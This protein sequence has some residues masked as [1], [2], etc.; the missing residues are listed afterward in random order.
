MM[1]ETTS[2]LIACRT[3]R[4]RA[5]VLSLLSLA[6]FG[7]AVGVDYI[8]YLSIGPTTL[9]TWYNKYWIG[10]FFVCGF[11]AAA[12]FVFR[13]TVKAK[14]EYLFLAITLSV[15]CFSSLAF[16]VNKTSW[17]VDV[18]YSYVVEWSEPDL[19]VALTDADARMIYGSSIESYLELDS[20]DEYTNELNQEDA[21]QDGR[22]VQGSIVNLYRSI[23]SLPASLVYAICTALAVPFS[24]K[25]VLVRLIYAL[26]YS[27]VTFFGMRQ[28]KSGKMLF[29]VIALLPTAVFLAAN[30]SYDYWINAFILLAIACLVRELQTPDEPITPKRIMVLLGS[31]IVAFGPKAIYF[32]LVLLCLLIPKS[33]FSSTRA[34]RLYRGSVILVCL[35]VAVSFL[36]PYV[37]LSGLGVGDVRGGSDVNSVGQVQFILSNPFGYARIL[38]SFLADYYSFFASRDY[39]AFY[40]Y[41][42]YSSWFLWALVYGL[43]IFTAIT[44]KSEADKTVCTW[45]SRVL[46]L[47]INVVTVVLVASA[48]YVSYTAVGSGIIAGCQPRYLIPL[49]FATLVFLSSS[50]LAWPRG[51]GRQKAAYNALILGAMSL[52]LMVGFWQVY[53]GLL[54]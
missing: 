13:H 26:I 31:F 12:F 43:L 36:M 46:A 47:A 29:A 39:I 34:S 32:P 16:D 30:Y 10:F 27:F 38:V 3:A 48:L 18:H 28:L 6:S 9:G 53:V 52:V 41:L 54:Y 8:C 2:S 21:L 44:D 45:K 17:D 14:P 51:G 50:R 42:G 7:L 24:L 40:A 1:R 20:L 5:I 49:L 22:T 19:D 37:F 23:S 25:Y 33:K 4:D 11:L 15:T 35:F